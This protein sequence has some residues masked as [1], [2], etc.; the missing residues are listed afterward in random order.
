MAGE[1]CRE[2][3]F[4]IFDEQIRTGLCDECLA[5]PQSER[6]SGRKEKEK[7]DAQIRE[8]QRQQTQVNWSVLMGRLRERYQSRQD[9]V[10]DPLGDLQAENRELR[11]EVEELRRKLSAK[12][13]EEENVPEVKSFLRNFDNLDLEGEE[14]E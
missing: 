3:G 6:L 9:P 2:C 8:E 12:E 1:T 11:R 13:I 14:N 7:R 10:R 4:L 5:L